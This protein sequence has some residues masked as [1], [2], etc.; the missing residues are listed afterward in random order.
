ML[1]KA[2]NGSRKKK[3]GDITGSISPS[4]GFIHDRYG[5]S[6]KRAENKTR[7]RG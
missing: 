4:E 7:M 5:I 6:I 3:I 1:N 2:V